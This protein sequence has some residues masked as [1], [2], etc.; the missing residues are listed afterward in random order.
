MGIESL[1]SAVAAAGFAMVLDEAGEG[2]QSRYEA[3][4][5]PSEMADPSAPA[6]PGLPAIRTTGAPSLG[7]RVSGLLEAFRPKG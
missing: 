3:K 6:A 7:E 4:G 2:E 1:N 5:S